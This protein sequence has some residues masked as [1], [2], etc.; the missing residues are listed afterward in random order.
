MQIHFGMQD[1]GDACESFAVQRAV[2]QFAGRPRAN[3]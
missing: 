3:S 2:A 1:V